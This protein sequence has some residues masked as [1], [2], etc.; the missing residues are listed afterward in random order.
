MV[1]HEHGYCGEFSDSKQDEGKRMAETLAQEMGMCLPSRT[2][3][4]DM[5][6]K[7]VTV[8]F[9][10]KGKFDRLGG[11]Q[12]CD[13][14]RSVNGV[15]QVPPDVHFVACHHHKKRRYSPLIRC[16]N[17]SLR[18]TR[19]GWSSHLRFESTSAV[20]LQSLEELESVRQWRR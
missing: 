13:F 18:V 20:M 19:A 8:P 7:L 6:P 12:I 5:L 4:V 16:I 14:G 17:S 10:E 2:A 1:E 9:E 15:I 11:R 3:R